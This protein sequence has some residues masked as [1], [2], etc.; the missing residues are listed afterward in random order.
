MGNI[1]NHTHRQ[2]RVDVSS[3]SG[4]RQTHFHNTDPTLDEHPRRFVRKTPKQPVYA[5]PRRNVHYL[6]DEEGRL[7]SVERARPV[8]MDIEHVHEVRRDRG[9]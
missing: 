2:T 3:L 4:R 8:P 5:N 1:L 9:L 6:Y 7:R